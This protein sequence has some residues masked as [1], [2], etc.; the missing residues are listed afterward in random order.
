[1]TDSIPLHVLEA[2]LDFYGGWPDGQYD[3]DVVVPLLQAEIERRR[4]EPPAIYEVAPGATERANA[5]CEA[6]R[7]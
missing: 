7:K 5:M 4:A 2:A 6:L 1:M 3:A